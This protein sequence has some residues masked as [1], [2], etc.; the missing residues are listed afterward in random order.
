[1]LVAEYFLLISFIPYEYMHI[2]FFCTD[3]IYSSTNTRVHIF[4]SWIWPLNLLQGVFVYMDVNI[5]STVHTSVCMYVYIYIC[6]KHRCA[7][8]TPQTDLLFFVCSVS[9]C[10]PVVPFLDVP[11]DFKQWVPDYVIIA[12]V[13]CCFKPA[14][15]QCL[16]FLRVRQ[17]VVSSCF[18]LVFNLFL[19]PFS[20]QL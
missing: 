3:K 11:R 12:S 5:Y 20:S 2:C 8:L 16:L 18:G 9:P 17:I 14:E 7:Y 4:C 13:F 1:M 15:I 19:D 10:C 6:I